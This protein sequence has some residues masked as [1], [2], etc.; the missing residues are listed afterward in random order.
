MMPGV[1]LPGGMKSGLFMAK[2]LHRAA[3]H[4]RPW[5]KVAGLAL[6]L[7]LLLLA[8]GGL[9]VRLL[10]PTE[11]V[12]QAV[13]ATLERTLGWQV[14]VGEVDFHLFRGITLRDVSIATPPGADSTALPLRSGTIERFVL[15]YRLLPLLQ[16]RLEI[17][18]ITLVKPQLDLVLLARSPLPTA[19]RDTSRTGLTIPVTLALHRLEIR[20]LACTVG[21]V[22]DTPRL[23]F[24]LQGLNFVASGLRLPRGKGQPWEEATGTIALTCTNAPAFFRQRGAGVVSPLE[25]S[26]RL[27]LELAAE[28]QT[29]ADLKATLLVGA[30][31]LRLVLPAKPLTEARFVPQGELPGVELRASLQADVLSG[32]YSLD[33]LSIALARQELLL[34]RGRLSGL[35]KSP[36]VEV[37][38]LEGRIFLGRLLAAIRPALSDS[39]FAALLPTHLSGTLSLA[40][41]KIEGVV[42]SSATGMELSATAVVD[43][44]DLS[45]SLPGGVEVAGVSLAGQG[46]AELDSLGVRE[47]DVT[48]S[49]SIDGAEYRAYTTPMAAAGGKLNLSVRARDRMREL[50]TDALVKI[51]RALGGELAGAIQLSIGPSASAWLGRV[52]LN[53]GRLP[54]AALT[55]GKVTGRV[56][57]YL[58]ATVGGLNNIG[59]KID[60]EADSLA[61]AVEGH[62]YSLPPLASRSVGKLRTDSRFALF[63][64]D[65]LSL[66]F[67]DVLSAKLAGKFSPRD[68]RFALQLRELTLH[69]RAL[70]ALLPLEL[71]GQLGEIALAGATHVR[72]AAS[73]NLV[74]ARSE[75]KVQGKFSSRVDADVPL[76][77]LSLA[78]GHVT[79]QAEVT[80]SLGK[81]TLDLAVTAL[82]F[83]Q[84][85]M[86]PITDAS[87]HFEA[88]MPEF[89]R[90]VLPRGALRLPSLATRAELTG[91]MV[92][93]PT[94]PLVSATVRLDL[95][96]SDTV[97][98]TDTVRLLGEVEAKVDFLMQDS[99]ASL[100]GKLFVPELAVYL[101]ANSALRGIRA[102][103]PFSQAVDLRRMKMATSPSEHYAYS[104]P[105]GLYPELFAP[106]LLASIPEQGWLSIDR[107]YFAGYGADNLRMRLF[108]GGGKLIVPSLLVDLY[109]GNFGG[110]L[111]VEMGDLELAHVRYRIEGHLSGVNS[112]LLAARRRQSLEKG[113]VNANF[114]FVGAGLDVRKSIELEGSFRITE[115]GPKVA[116]N[117]LQSLDPHGV[118][119]GIR[120]AR[121]LINHG[122]KPRLMTFD[123]RHGHLYP[124]ITLSQ[125][126]YFPLRISGSGRQEGKVELA[127]IPV[128]FFLQ[129][130]KQEA[131]PMY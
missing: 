119:A 84:L 31:R 33:K 61:M 122:F 99:V 106:H 97:R 4:R 60:V 66:Q 11:R 3:L 109:E 43:L 73:G 108:V 128:A 81:A 75:L 88:E 22:T 42:P 5:L 125:P 117:L 98:V 79:G 86:A 96:A 115:I 28:A 46:T 7:Y 53:I 17:T 93:K 51:S 2:A 23:D 80:P 24:A 34:C 19:T 129:M 104:G 70:P 131:V 47:G 124:S 114:T 21:I 44:R 74:P 130:L 52:D 45:F 55:S 57:S 83:A 8:G 18:E 27:N 127:R 116:D 100:G 41:T 64:V 20:Q 6:A 36:R 95:Q 91:S 110:S 82:S 15:G 65:S 35:S 121:F 63:A 12:R 85:P 14:A 58:A 103:I 126:W 13:L 102:E 56:S 77:G 40:G 120:S 68:Q 32:D 76:L 69:H 112:A 49:M 9:L 113:V 78:G 72:A 54:L 67:A 111:A 25:V 30:Q 123:L 39:T 107:L 62:R 48:A 90:V 29:L 1:P 16:R 50:H 87:A 26:G 89:R 101:P 118:D 92:P 71:Q 10:V 38:L 94:G 37:E 59:L 105:G